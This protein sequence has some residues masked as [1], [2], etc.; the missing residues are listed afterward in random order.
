MKIIHI[1]NFYGPKSGG[2]KTTLHNLGTEYQKIGHEFIYVVPGKKFSREKT[3]H[4][5]CITL[6]SWTIPFSGGYRVI[7]STRQVKTILQSLKPDRLEVSDRFTLSCLGN[8]AK[9]RDI[10]AIVFSH[11]TL[12]GL[13]KN[14][15]G[16]SLKPI[17]G[18]HNSRLAGKFDFVVTTT[19]FA[20]A[21]FNDI[22]TTNVVRVPLGVDLN[23]FSPDHR[24]E[25]LRAKMIKGGDVLLV[26][27]GRLSPEKKPERSLQT[28]RE[29]L[30][31]GINARLVYI[32]SGPLHKKLYDSSRDIPVTFWGYVANKNLLAQMIAS[33][34]V[35]LAPGPIETFCLAAL[36]S[37]ASGTP[38]VA[39]ETS[40]VGEF[41]YEDN[42]D[43][44][45]LTAANNGAAFAD[46]VEIILEEIKE[47]PTLSARC[48]VQAERFPWSATIHRLD[49]L[50]PEK[51]A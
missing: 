20:A 27:C 6:P 42:G 13:V 1:A 34:D 18:W 2:I 28:L 43:F 17:V 24:N 23:T 4:G 7:R 5:G 3:E 32:G 14:F 45:G 50:H 37:L 36:E 30:N 31:R 48:R 16:V 21:E 12:R 49:T 51:V 33:A 44:V 22:G 29:L 11:E 26:H 35:S 46:A 39:S 15:F 25:E 9:R 19:N 38:V 47:D 10:P 41:L 8:W 40:A